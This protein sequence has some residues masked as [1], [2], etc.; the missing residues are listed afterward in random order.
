MKRLRERKTIEVMVALYC[1]SYHRNDKLCSDCRELLD[2][3]LE[4]LEKCPFQEHKT[5]CVKC[6]VHCYKPVMRERV[7]AVMRYA[8]PRMS[9]RHPIL[10]LFHFID[11]LR[12]EPVYPQDKAKND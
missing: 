8:G 2:Y 4:H 6:P 7:R 3:A 1:H 9:Y 5:T 11:G 12:K 10:A